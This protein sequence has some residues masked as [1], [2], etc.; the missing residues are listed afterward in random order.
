MQE[1]PVDKSRVGEDRGSAMDRAR[2]YFQG[3]PKVAI[4]A[5]AGGG[6]VLIALSILLFQNMTDRG[7]PA[8]VGGIQA[9]PGMMGTPTGS[10]IATNTG[11]AGAAGTV[12]TPTTTTPMGTAGAGGGTSAAGT[13][14]GVK[15]AKNTL[16]AGAAGAGGMGGAAMGGQPAGK[17]GA[18][19]AK[20]AGAK[21]AA[22]AKKA[23]KPQ[24]GQ[25]TG[26]GGA[27]G[28]AM[29]GP[30]GAAGAAGTGGAAG[31]GGFTGM[32]GATAGTGAA[33][34]GQGA[35]QVAKAPPGV[36]TRRNPFA[37]TTEL[38]GVIASVR[39]AQAAQPIAEAHPLYQE[40]NPPKPQVQLATDD[41]DGPPV[42][43]MR[44]SA[45]V[46]G[47]QVAAILQMG[48]QYFQVTPGKMIPDDN[49]VFRVE[50]I[51]KD[52]VLLTRRWRLGNRKGVQR[53]TVPLVGSATQTAGTPG[54]GFP[55]GMMGAPG[56]AS[57]GAPGSGR[58]NTAD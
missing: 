41:N 4:G 5:A 50:K 52:K 18:A 54:G 13:A 11:P 32:T 34:T 12:T 45:T 6:A 20:T 51:E 33:G 10:D 42:P 17:A 30:A 29:G 16:P 58:Q 53:I 36:P 15:M 27:A 47:F 37:P 40:L 22:G 25:R 3:N 49:P 9:N 35:D 26:L 1:P 56:G 14:P 39:V 7:E 21:G 57:G 19:G 24:A 55:G 31:M 48:D 23:A 43:A 2:E 38:R 44:V 46:E 8:P 28:A